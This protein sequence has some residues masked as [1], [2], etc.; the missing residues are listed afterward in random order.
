MTHLES[1]RAREAR[2]AGPETVRELLREVRGQVRSDSE[3]RWLLSAATGSSISQLVCSLDRAVRNGV[4]EEVGRMLGRR[5]AGEPLQYVLGK[6]SFRTLELCVDPR[7]LIPRPETEQLVGYALDELSNQALAA[8]SDETI[9]AVDLGTGSGAIALSLSAEGTFCDPNRLEVWATDV[10][11]DALDVARTNLGLVCSTDP[12]AAARVRLREGSWFDAV[13]EDLAGRVRLLVS[14][15][16]YVSAGEWEGL[17]PVVR[18]HEPC[19][20]LV[21]GDVGLEMLE[22]IVASAPR[23]L[24]AGGALV[25]EMAPHQ[26][27][28]VARSA[29]SAGFTEVEVRPDLAGFPRALVAH[30]PR[31]GRLAR[32]D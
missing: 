24:A 29:R 26:A 5:R 13:P 11:T 22:L 3:A 15:P 25:L 17:D 32:G 14:N 1:T 30:W 27:D 12:R 19:R 16:P 2:S 6:W 4:A 20:A 18:D 21:A 23:W 8:P 10:S 31:G 9:V 28:S 7:V